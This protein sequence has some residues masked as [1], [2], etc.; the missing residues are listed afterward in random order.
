MLWCGKH[1]TVAGWTWKQ[2]SKHAETEAVNPHSQKATA[3]NVWSLCSPWQRECT[4]GSQRTLPAISGEKRS[5]NHRSY[6]RMP[7]TT[8]ITSQHSGNDWQDGV[9]RHGNRLR[10]SPLVAGKKCACMISP[11]SDGQ[12]REVK[13][14]NVY[15]QSTVMMSLWADQTSDHAENVLNMWNMTWKWQYFEHACDRVI[16]LLPTSDLV[17]GKRDQVFL[18]FIMRRNAFVLLN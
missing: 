12:E 2:G 16:K 8:I 3:G 6:Y 18:D 11:M 15:V 13:V 4:P 10:I 1:K 17:T 5:T 14:H 7:L 9:S